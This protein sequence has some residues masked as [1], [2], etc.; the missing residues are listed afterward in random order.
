MNFLTVKD[1]KAFAKLD[2]CVFLAT[3]ARKH[4]YT[5]RIKFSVL[6]CISVADYQCKPNFAVNKRLFLRPDFT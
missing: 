6:I 2:S 1:T 3:E 4:G 5:S